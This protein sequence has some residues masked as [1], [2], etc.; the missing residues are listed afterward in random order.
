MA[1]AAWLVPGVAVAA[2]DGGAAAA[3]PMRVAANDGA[4]AAAAKTSADPKF[5]QFK[6]A[7]DSLNARILN[8]SGV[9]LFGNVANRGDG[10]VE[11]TVTPTWLAAPKKMRTGNLETLFD[12]WKTVDDS[13][14][15][16]QVRMVDQSGKLVME[17]HRR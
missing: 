5:A 12:L 6:S 14:R 10:T 11:I 3:P 9:S 7:I 1:F 4:D 15:P 16:I 17:R 2:G 8:S 13:T